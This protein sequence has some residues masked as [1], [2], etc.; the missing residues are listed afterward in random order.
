[1]L[2]V[3]KVLCKDTAH[4]SADSDIKIPLV[5]EWFIIFILSVNKILHTDTLSINKILCTDTVSVN[6]AYQK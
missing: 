4:G 1:M 6:K 2:S 3:N 5:A